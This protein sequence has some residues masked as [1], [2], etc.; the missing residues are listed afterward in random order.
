M[1]LEIAYE[2]IVIFHGLCYWVNKG[3]GHLNFGIVALDC[4]CRL[5]S[6]VFFDKEL[7]KDWIIFRFLKNSRSATFKLEN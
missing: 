7:S 6:S 4:M 1:F 5:I 3:I 2:I